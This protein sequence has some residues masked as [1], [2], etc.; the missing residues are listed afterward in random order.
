[1]D[2]L[3]Y[4]PGSK[5]GKRPAPPP[6]SAEAVLKAKKKYDREK[7]QRSFMPSWQQGRDWLQ[8]E[9][10]IMFCKACRSHYGT[11]GASCDGPSTSSQIKGGKAF[12]DGNM[13]FKLD[14][15]KALESSS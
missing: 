4:V 13:D 7:Q 14:S 3:R 2:K 15:I 11:A 12:I 6:R 8:Y 1:M 10:G 5:P 9:S